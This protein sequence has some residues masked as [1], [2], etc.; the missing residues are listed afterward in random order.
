MQEAV[1]GIMDG[2]GETVAERMQ[3]ELWE[4]MLKTLTV[5]NKIEAA[6]ALN[7][8]RKAMAA[9]RPE[10]TEN[11]VLV[12]EALLNHLLLQ[13]Y[14]QVEVRILGLFRR[15]VE[16]RAKGEEFSFDKAGN[17]AEDE[18]IE[19]EINRSILG[20]Y[21]NH[22]RLRFVRGVNICR[23][24][25]SVLDAPDVR[26]E[27]YDFYDRPDP[28]E[29]KPLSIL[30]HLMKRHWF[31]VILSALIRMAQHLVVLFVPILTGWIIDETVQSG[32]FFSE[33]VFL[34]IALAVLSILANLVFYGLQTVIYHRFT[35]A[36]ETG[37][38]MALLR[39]LQVLS[40][41]YQ[42]RT[43]SG[44]LLSKI[45]SDVQFIGILLYD[46]VSD[47]LQLLVDL[48]FIAV[49]AIQICPPILAFYLIITPLGFLLIRGYGQIVLKRKGMM[50]HRTEESNAEIKEAL[51]INQV[52]RAQGMQNTIYR[53]IAAGVLKAQEASNRYDDVNIHVNAVSFGTVQ[54]LRL[55]CLCLAAYLV[56]AGYISIGQVLMIQSV[57]DMMINSSQH[58]L[59]GLPQII[60][61]YDSLVSVHEVLAERDV[62]LNGTEKLKEPVQGEIELKD[63]SFA[64]DEDTPVLKNVSL[65]IPAGSCTAFIGPSGAGK[66]TL[67]NLILGLYNPT[68]GE[69]TIDGKRLNELEK[70]SFRHHVAVVPQQTVLFSGTLYEN[71][72]CGMP[73]ISPARVMET[74]KAVGL[75]D[76]VRSLPDGLYSHLQENGENLSGGQRQR[77]AIARAML[78]DAEIL[79]FDE[80]TSALDT[81]S[82]NQVQQA[83]D[84]L[85]GKCTMVMVAH[86]LN[87][88][89]KAD[90]VWKVENGGVF[91]CK[92][93]FQADS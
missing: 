56:S 45:I 10:N 9:D 66:S 39:K 38:K 33:K 61:G 49:T 60:Q 6:E 51:A 71:L 78:R 59:D 21:E 86:R 77:I 31:R 42:S 17:A 22:I 14:D 81:E 65:K 27:I 11:C 12:C 93:D 50:R 23:I 64:Y 4:N 32:T 79:I 85:M 8:I 25:F 24:S 1:Y 7:R 67:L 91:R 28:G 48:I 72:T 36:I 54:G 63:V 29:R 83:I 76:L 90:A 15:I 75:Q 43:R 37:F 20:Q 84:A 89:R 41:K 13:G 19:D 70:S 26:A 87:T 92:N 55:A 82:E 58:V 35:R 52:T 18:R 57:F 44:T 68:E 88:I 3:K 34:N 69:I 40:M 62:E 2:T 46:R 30:K 47:L 80:A 16:I 53:K 74:L 73:L 5:S